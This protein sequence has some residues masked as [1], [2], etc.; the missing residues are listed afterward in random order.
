MTA[1]LLRSRTSAMRCHRDS[2]APAPE[3]DI[4]IPGRLTARPGR[5]S[6]QTLVQ[7]GAAATTLR[8]QFTVQ[9]LNEME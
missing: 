9:K 6:C 3:Q 4:V 8:A 2:P 1:A 5:Q 7:C